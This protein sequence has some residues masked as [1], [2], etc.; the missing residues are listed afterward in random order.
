MYSCVIVDDEPLA[1]AVLI[2]YIND[3]G[4]LGLI[5][6]FFSADKAV[7]FLNSNKVDLLF[8][9]IE[10]PE[11]SGLELLKS[12]TE[13][14]VTI[15]TTAFLDYALEGFELGVLD[16]LVKPIHYNRFSGAVTRAL[17]FLDLLR[18]KTS[19]ELQPTDHGTITIKSDN[20]RISFEKNEITYTQG[21]KDYVIIYCTNK[22][23]VIRCTMKRMEEILGT[24][25]FLRTHKSFIVAKKKV[26]YVSGNK[27]LLGGFEIPI[28]RK[29]KTI[30]DDF[31]KSKHR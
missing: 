26:D 15:I 3:V 28:G 4:G 23:Y 1:H 16:Y 2:S 6:Q 12:L 10:M 17:E 19:L 29:Y 11:K 25:L 27:V 9:D 21:L 8:L 22:K 14:P 18:L 24:E 5:N 31:F 30:A 20:K 13:K 7:D